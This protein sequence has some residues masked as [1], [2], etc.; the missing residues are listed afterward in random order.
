MRRIN[1]ILDEKMLKKPFNMRALL[2]AI[3][4]MPGESGVENSAEAV[5][6]RRVL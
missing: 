5:L 3:R 2:F 6:L 1:I 4:P